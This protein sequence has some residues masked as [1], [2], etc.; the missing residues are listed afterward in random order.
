[1][2]ALFLTRSRQGI[3][4]EVPK[5]FLLSFAKIERQERAQRNVVVQGFVLVQ[6]LLSWVK[7]ALA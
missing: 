7:D 1:V 4:M 2:T 5:D 6:G 3:T